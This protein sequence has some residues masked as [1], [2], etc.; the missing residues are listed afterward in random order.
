LGQGLHDRPSGKHVGG[1]GSVWWTGRQRCGAL[2]SLEGPHRAAIGHRSVD[3]GPGAAGLVSPGAGERPHPRETPGPEGHGPSSASIATASPRRARPV[4]GQ[5]GELAGV[6]PS[7]GCMSREVRRDVALSV[8]VIAKPMQSDWCRSAPGRLGRAAGA[9][10]EPLAATF[11]ADGAPGP[12]TCAAAR[13]RRSGTAHLIRW[14]ARGRA[15]T[16]GCSSTVVGRSH[17]SLCAPKDRP[18]PRPGRAV[19]FPP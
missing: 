10:F 4:A 12:R 18:R 7:G 5:A 14:A 9:S 19:A 1:N 17:P 16:N 8:A 6:G 2:T 15:R 11:D 3:E 13:L